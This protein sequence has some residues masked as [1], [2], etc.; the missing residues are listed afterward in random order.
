MTLLKTVQPQEQGLYAAGH[1]LM[2]LG[3]LFLS[4]L[5]A[6]KKTTHTDFE[7]NPPQWRQSDSPFAPIRSW[8]W[9]NVAYLLWHIVAEFLLGED[10][11]TSTQPRDLM[12]VAALQWLVRVIRLVR[13][14][15]GQQR[16][17]SRE[18]D[19]SPSGQAQALTQL[20]GYRDPQ[21]KIWALAGVCYALLLAS[22]SGP[23]ATGAE[24]ASLA[25][26]ELHNLHAWWEEKMA[27]WVESQTLP[28]C[29]LSMD[30]LDKVAFL[31][32]AEGEMVIEQLHQN[33]VA[34]FGS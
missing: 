4:L 14:T 12:G 34:L 28:W 18:A 31:T 23:A 20:Q 10:H 29:S 6:S 17:Q 11:L 16:V 5:E 15:S 1:M 30:V 26:T 21:T 2:R 32:S 8:D 19:P 33:T 7:F 24:P 25:Q 9:A 27:A 22:M 13:S 3:L